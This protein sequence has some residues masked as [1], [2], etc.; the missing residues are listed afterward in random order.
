MFSARILMAVLLVVA[1]ACTP[2]PQKPKTDPG[3]AETGGTATSST[4]GGESDTRSGA[5]GSTGSTGSTTTT[6]T[7]TT[8]SDSATSTAGST[9][10]ISS[11]P[12]LR[13]PY[14]PGTEDNV[15]NAATATAPTT[16]GA[17]VTYTSSA[18]VT[19]TSQPVVK[20]PVATQPA[21]SVVR[22]E[23]ELAAGS[24]L[25]AQIV[26]NDSEGIDLRSP[27][28]PEL[29][30][31]A[32]GKGYNTEVGMLARS[33]FRMP[34]LVQIADVPT[35]KLRLKDVRIHFGPKQKIADL[36]PEDVQLCLLTTLKCAPVASQIVAA[37]N[38]GKP[39]AVTV[40][41]GRLYE[42][43]ELE[44]DLLQVFSVRATES[45][46]WLL[47]QSAAFA[48][49][50]ERK[51]AFVVGP[52]VSFESGR[53][54]VRYQVNTPQSADPKRGT[55]AL[56]PQ[57]VENY[58]PAVDTRVSEAKKP[59]GQG[60]GNAS[61]KTSTPSTSNGTRT[62]VAAPGTVFTFSFP[63]RL[64]HFSSQDPGPNA[65]ANEL[66]KRSHAAIQEER[67][68]IASIAIV[69][70]PDAGGDKL[71][72]RNRAYALAFQLMGSDGKYVGVGGMSRPAAP[73]APQAAIR[74]RYQDTVSLAD[75]KAA[76]ARLQAA[77][78]AIW[79]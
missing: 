73:G 37:L 71:Q 35:L 54:E 2:A 34:P 75:R 10:S 21:L 3:S 68:K 9:G 12:I 39:A 36:S 70:A 14:S 44:L 4:G 74:I 28:A 11:A 57:D 20:S 6:T 24:K 23:S 56:G 43:G 22:Y 60:D 59:A 66:L 69:A 67:P 18:P 51:F 8:A 41:T 38:A 64:L 53:L 65:S 79:K 52:R 7:T 46:T 76:T 62:R 58:V 26:F 13:D 63:S 32:S 72:G 77:F 15:T 78:G 47:T 16:N 45:G 25:D 49:P 19:T 42:I 50:D 55:P 29:Q 33:V 40:A 17:S 1:S 48:D 30:D 5:T 61:N 27:Q 31:P